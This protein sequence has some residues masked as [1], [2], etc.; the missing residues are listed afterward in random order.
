MVVRKLHWLD[1]FNIS[2]SSRKE[3]YM[4]IIFPSFGLHTLFLTTGY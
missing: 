3:N 2:L 4:N 1:T